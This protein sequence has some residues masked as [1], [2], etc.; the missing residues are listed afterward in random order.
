[1]DAARDDLR[2]AR[3]VMWLYVLTAVAVF[4]LM[5]VVGLIMRGEQ[6]QWISFGPGLFYSLMT[7]HGIGM[8]TAVTIA[9]MGIMWYLVRRDGPLDARVAYFCYASLVLG[10]V[11]VLAAVL[12]GRFAAAWTFLYPLPFV[13]A[14]W[15]SWA[16]G[17]FLI[18]V[19]L[20]NLGW[21][22][23]CVQILGACVSRSGGLGPALGIDYIFRRSSFDAAGKRPPEPQAIAATVVGFNGVL[24]GTAGMVIGTALIAHWLNPSIVLDP[25]WA[26]NVT[27]FFGHSIA[28]LTIYMVVAGV[29][30]A[31]P[32]YTRREY[33]TSPVFVVAWWGTLLFVATAY[34]H[35]LYMDFAQLRALQYI[36]EAASYLA[37]V[38]VA[39]VTV[40]GSAMLVYRSAMRWT[41]GSLMIFTGLVGWLVG[42][43]GALL[44]AT[45][46]FNFDLHNT[47]W[48][49]AH[50][51]T[52]LLE[53]V[54]LFV[55]GWIF[56]MLEQRSGRVTS[57]AMRWLTGLTFFGGGAV[58]LLGFYAAG[59][60]GVPRRFAT[61]PAPG[62]DIAAW[63]T[64][65][66]LILLVGMLLIVVEAVRLA[67]AP[68]SAEAT[69]S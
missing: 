14:T 69:E 27:F 17:S 18:G 36:G 23:W 20:V 66:A 41:L 45:V 56:F 44:D 67:L 52:Y 55:F 38:P 11:A 64:I 63:S 58:F 54:A 19:A 43:V 24:T 10:V 32:V 12:I 50:F 4:S 37:A 7:L 60:A 42:G 53:G 35:H 51:H 68:K 59:A 25:L 48:V 2:S 34:F 49:P 5:L 61:E 33:H 30:V 8:I 31:L 9:G 57:I 21:L 62:P 47:L 13:G 22:I 26:K 65:G 1:V 6:A 39:V 29:Y 28:N 15:P 40:Y 3:T 16:T 46:P